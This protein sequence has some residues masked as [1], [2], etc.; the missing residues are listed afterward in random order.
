M[1]TNNP[2]ITMYSIIFV[3]INTKAVAYKQ[4]MIFQILN[5]V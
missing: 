5:N 3:W 2:Q 1:I 4:Q